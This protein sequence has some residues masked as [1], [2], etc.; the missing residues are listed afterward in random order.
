MKGIEIYL[1]I[2]LISLCLIPSSSALNVTATVGESWIV[3]R[4]SPNY[5]VNVYIDGIKQGNSTTSTDWY[6]TDINSDEKHQIK[7]F[8]ATNSSQLLGSLTVTTLHSQFIILILI[9]VLIIF[10]ILLLFLN[11]PIKTLLVGGLSFS[12]SLYTSQISLGYGAL[13]IIP[14]VTLIISGIFSAYALWSIII[15]K[16]RW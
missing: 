8:N 11:D 16:T 5:T 10:F 7:L 6:L 14:L 2:C 12:I 13:T 15:E 1:L 4:W 9:C 3:Y